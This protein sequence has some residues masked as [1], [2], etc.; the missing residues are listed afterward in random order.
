[1][2][3]LQGPRH[4]PV[5]HAYAGA[6]F[7]AAKNFPLALLAMCSITPEV[8]V[9]RRLLNN[10]LEEEG[11]QCADDRRGL[12]LD[13]ARSHLSWAR[14]FALAAGWTEAA[15]D[16]LPA[17]GSVDLADYLAR[18]DWFAALGYLCIGFEYNVPPACVMVSDRLRE[19]GY[20]QQDLTFFS[21]HIQLD[22]E[23]GLEGVELAE[24]YARTA[25]Q[26]DSVLRGTRR[27]VREWC[28]MHD[29]CARAGRGT[30]RGDTPVSLRSSIVP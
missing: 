3:A 19:L 4:A 15:L 1:M 18:G 2:R 24:V 28:L 8:E 27:G 13:E 30:H 25:E 21:A 29:L 14:R 10:L 26:R 22:A 23:H 16:A 17:R 7:Q 11:F 9:R 5:I 20:T 12:Q 6:M